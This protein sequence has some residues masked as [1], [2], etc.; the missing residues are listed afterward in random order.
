MDQRLHGVLLALSGD[1]ADLLRAIDTRGSGLRVVRR[2]ADTAELL[3]AAMAGLAA[4]V[5]ADT[6]FDELDRSVLDRLEH[7]GV[8]GIILAPAEQV[9]RWATVGWPVE[10]RRT[11]PDAVR[12]R[13]QALA[14]ALEAGRGE[15][16]EPPES[17]RTAPVPDTG[18]DDRLWTELEDVILQTP[19]TPER[20]DETADPDAPTRVRVDRA[21]R[22]RQAWNRRGSANGRVWEPMRIRERRP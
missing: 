10:D 13:L 20:V 6:E 5:V 8:T 16:A 21:H 22:R 14:H 12:A 11:R 1:D 2:C 18:A 3:S 19:A 15:R 4:L 9:E 7:A 17:L